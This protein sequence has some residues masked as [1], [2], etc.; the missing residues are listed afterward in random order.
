MNGIRSAVC[1]TPG[2][3]RGVA[4][5][6]GATSTRAKRS[7]SRRLV[8]SAACWVLAMGA[9]AVGQGRI[10]NVV[11][12]TRSAAQGLEREIGTIAARGTPVWIGYSV[13]MGPGS[14][15]FCS[16]VMLEPPTQLLILARLDQG[17][18]AK[19]RTL[20]P[21]CEVDAG[22]VP[23]VWL[24]NVN[25]AQSVA[26]L[27]GFVSPSTDRRGEAADLTRP[28]LNAIGLHA[29]DA[30]PKLIQIVR[31]TADRQLRK[32]AMSWLGR[33]RDPQAVRFF[34]ELLNAE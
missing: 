25:P 29:T 5:G 6:S 19:L 24:T 15:G 34:E 22:D 9:L 27:A 14:G 7:S 4:G 8:G 3:V 18:V 21:N 12:E 30:A 26:W 32:Q 11:T 17:K 28:A 20:T 31:T 33:S 10:A 2:A 16:A 13:P 1:G 23:V